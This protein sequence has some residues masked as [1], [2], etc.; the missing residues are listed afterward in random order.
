METKITKIVKSSETSGERERNQFVTHVKVKN[1]CSYG[2][3]KQDKEEQESS[4]KAWV[5]GTKV[6][7]KHQSYKAWI[8]QWRKIKGVVL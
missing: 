2:A 3:Q 7:M 8:K 6:A 4:R 1:E 5:K